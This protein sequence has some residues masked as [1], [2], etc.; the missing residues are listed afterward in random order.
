MAEEVGSLRLPV[1]KDVEV[2]LIKLADGRIVSRTR[3]E[4][5]AMKT[6]KEGGK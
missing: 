3:E 4:V 6:P 5:E 1:R 2:V